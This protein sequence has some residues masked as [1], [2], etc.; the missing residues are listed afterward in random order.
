MSNKNFIRGI[1]I[2]QRHS[3]GNSGVVNDGFSSPLCVQWG[4]QNANGKPTPWKWTYPCSFK[5]RPQGVAAT[6]LGGKNC[7]S[8]IIQTITESYLTW[9]DQDY[10]GSTGAGDAINFIVVGW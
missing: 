7:F 8:E 4:T 2:S 5:S 1:S 6:R 9:I 10:Q 3:Y